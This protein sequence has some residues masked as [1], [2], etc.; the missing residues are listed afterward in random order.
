MDNSQAI[1]GYKQ[2]LDPA[3][4]VAPPCFVVFLNI[5]PDATSHVNGAVLAVSGDQLAELDRRERNYTRIEVT[6]CLGEAVAGTVW[7]YTGSPAAIARFHAGL[8]AGTA[9]ISE[10]Y[11]QAVRQGFAALGDDAI[12][13]FQALTDP[14]PCPLV[15][16]RRVPV[17]PR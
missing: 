13:E 3:T 17:A 14:V 15:P 2:Y 10:T 6:S 12:C 11:A 4:G 9:V 1:P 16:L 8:R 5:V 7:T